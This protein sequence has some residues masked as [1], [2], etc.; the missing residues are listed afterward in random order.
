MRRFAMTTRRSD[1]S[2]SRRTALAGLG[3]GSLATALGSASP[4]SAQDGIDLST[5][6]LA[7]TWAVTTTG[8]IVPQHHGPD[9][10][11]VAYFPPNYVDPA[12]GLTYQGPALGQWEADGARGAR[13]T[14]IQALSDADGAYV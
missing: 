14:F 12:L 8:G 7:G 1:R 9:G 3:A 2:V 4:A 11:I 6:P 10:A 13:F 5:H